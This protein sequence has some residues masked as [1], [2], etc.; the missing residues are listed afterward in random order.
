[1]IMWPPDATTT[2]A[3]GDVVVTAWPWALV[4][5]I[6]AAGTREEVVI[7]EPCALVVVIGISTLTDAEDTKASVLT[8][9][10]LPSD[11]VDGTTTGTRTP[12]AVP[13]EVA[14][15]V[16]AVMAAG[17]LTTVLPAASVVVTG[18]GVDAAITDEATSEDTTVLPAESVVVMATVVGESDAGAE[19]SAEDAAED[20]NTDEPCTLEGEA[21]PDDAGTEVS[22][23]TVLAAPD[24]CP[25][26]DATTTV[27]PPAALL[28]GTEVRPSV[29]L[30][31]AS[32]VW[33]PVVLGSADV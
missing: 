26:V 16:A 4:V 12:L 20:P 13:V 14:D 11:S 32:D 8:A 17:V 2:L 6:T 22:P 23:A 19:L 27:V 18:A 29:E 3:T 5:V 28:A 9:V 33:P 21:V 7:V 30:A 1:M 25:P 15:T 10:T 31:G 24:V